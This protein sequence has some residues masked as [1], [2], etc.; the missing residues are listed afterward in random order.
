MKKFRCR[1]SLML[2]F[3]L[4]VIFLGC[5]LPLGSTP[6]LLETVADHREF[7]VDKFEENITISPN[8]L[9]SI[10]FNLQEGEEF[11]IIFTL[12][13]KETLP[14]DVWFVNEDHYLL[15]VNG[16]QFLFFIDGSEQ[17]VTYTKKIVTLTEHDLYKLVMT[18]YY[19]NQTV[20]VNVIYEIRAYYAYSGETSYLYPLLFAIVILV[21]LVIV[22][23]IKYRGLKQAEP[24]VS[25]KTSSKKGKT[26]KAKKAE[27]KINEKALSKKAKTR[28]PKKEEP[29]AVEIAP[30]KEAVEP[31]VF[32]KTPSPRFCGHCGKPVDTPY[33]KHCG[34]KV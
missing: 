28:K 33:C 29:K 23:F 30:S 13:V 7:E 24:K 6:Y 1:F 27:S 2:C 22:L 4:L 3:I 9:Q 8:G 21:V 15:L 14:I 17:E 19:N 11:E 16:A 18:N 12:Q 26:H 34:R 10:D 31:R 20:E 25:K 5:N 32:E